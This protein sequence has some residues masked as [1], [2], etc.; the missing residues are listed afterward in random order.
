MGAITEAEVEVEKHQV[1]NPR[2]SWNEHHTTQTAVWSYVLDKAIFLGL[3][4]ALSLPV[5]EGSMP[6]HSERLAPLGEMHRP[7]RP[8]TPGETPR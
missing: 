5:L 3:C 7:A 6:Q 8:C 1:V 2:H 4:M